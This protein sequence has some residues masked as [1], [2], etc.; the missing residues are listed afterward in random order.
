MTVTDKVY[1]NILEQ[2]NEGIYY[3]DTERKITYWNKAA[4]TISG[5][6]K[7][8]VMG[9]S[10]ADNLLRHIDESGNEMCKND[11]PI[12]GAILK[13]AGAEKNI[14][15]HH[16]NG[17]R[18]KVFTRITPIRN[19]N[20]DVVGAVELFTDLTNDTHTELI[21]ELEKLK[22]EV[23]SDALTQIGN[24]KYGE[25]TLER[26]FR[27][28]QDY[29]IP[30]SIFFIDIDFFKKINDTYGHC[31]GDSVLKMVSKSITSLLRSMDVVCRWGGE[32]FIIISPNITGSA[33][34]MVGERIRRFIEQ[35]WVQ[36][37]SDEM[38]YCTI[39]IGAASVQN[40]DTPAAILKRAD[41]AMYHSK[42]NGRNK[43]T[44]F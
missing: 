40:G 39:S 1:E 17:H 10:C 24:R 26:R 8:E 15:L 28:W 29:R 3:V 43:L 23:Y 30:F 33:V 32:E 35:S 31:T 38:V 20:G 2:L 21:S 18:V 41:S 12:T 44:I 6:T 36:S 42:Q 22:K 4:E 19:N 16:K 14:Y 7:E 27:D 25:I 9:R 37:A 5:Y 34:T 13:G 11:C